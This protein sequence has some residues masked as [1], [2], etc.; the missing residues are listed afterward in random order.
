[1]AGHAREARVVERFSA[2]ATW[3]HDNVSFLRDGVLQG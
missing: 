3:E 2:L 1:M